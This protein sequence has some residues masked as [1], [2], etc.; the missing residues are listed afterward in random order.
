[1]YLLS[2]RWPLLTLTITLCLQNIMKQ[3]E[4]SLQYALRQVR[5]ACCENWTTSLIMV[6]KY[7]GTIRNKMEQSSW[8]K[9]ADI[10]KWPQSN[11]KLQAILPSGKSHWRYS[12]LLH[13][14]ATCG[15]QHSTPGGVMCVLRSHT[16][17]PISPMCKMQT[18]VSHSS[19]E[20]EIIS[21]DG[22]LRIDGLPALQ[23]W[24]CVLDIVL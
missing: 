15:I 14:Q 20:S 4:S 2:S 18:A 3:R 1:M 5:N 17:V 11:Q 13:V 22:S 12:R 9:R 21:F 24:A 6:S 16:F 23:F 19:A 8:Q 7:F 10:D